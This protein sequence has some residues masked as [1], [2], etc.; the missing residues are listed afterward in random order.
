MASRPEIV[1]VLRAVEQ[2]LAVDLGYGDRPDTAV[3]SPAGV[4]VELRLRHRL[5]DLTFLSMAA[6]VQ[7]ALD[8]T[9]DELTL[10]LFHP[11]DDA[12]RTLMASL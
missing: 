10:E 2:P 4:A 5:G 7:T 9:V 1:D 11:A 6:S 12:T 8:V 3:E